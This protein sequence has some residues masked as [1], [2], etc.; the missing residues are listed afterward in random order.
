MNGRGL[1]VKLV[2]PVIVIAIVCLAASSIGN[3]P[4]DRT[5]KYRFSQLAAHRLVA[6]VEHPHEPLALRAAVRVLDLL[7][8]AG[9]TAEGA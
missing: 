7:D 2:F 6:M 3:D 1:F 5:Q 8:A 4:G 9:P